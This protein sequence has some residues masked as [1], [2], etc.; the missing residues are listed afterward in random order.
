MDIL[1]YAMKMELDGKAFYER[2]ASKIKEPGLQKILLTLAEEEEKHYRF[3]KNLKE[4]DFS[5]AEEEIRSSSTLTTTRNIFQK[6][7]DEGEGKSFGEDEQS[8]W[9]E[10]MKIEEKAEKMYREQAAKETDPTRKEMLT[11]IANEEQQH[12]YLIDNVLTYL[13]F[14]GTFADSSQFKDFKSWEGK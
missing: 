5:A 3:F 6:L 10:A 9:I 2:H 11:Q 8:V 12:I 7:A 4:G 13:K 1:D 14:P